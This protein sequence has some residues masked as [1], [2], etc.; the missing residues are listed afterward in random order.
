MRLR[1]IPGS[2][3]AIEK[4]PYVIQNPEEYKGRW[5]TVFKN[6]HDICIEVGMGKGRFLMEMAE[7]NPDLNY[8]G[9][10]MYSSVLLRAV[11][12]AEER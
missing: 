1:N 4:S 5:N 10:E 3:E 9:I 6:D 8:I 11:Q 2:R 12:K 7:N